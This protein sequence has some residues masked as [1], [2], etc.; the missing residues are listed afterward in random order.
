MILS[1]PSQ[2]LP[3]FTSPVASTSDAVN[4]LGSIRIPG[5]PPQ[6]CAG[7]H[8]TERS[9][10]AKPSCPS[11]GAQGICAP[12]QPGGAQHLQP[13]ALSWECQQSQRS[14]WGCTCSPEGVNAVELGELFQP[15]ASTCPAPPVTQSSV[16]HPANPRR[17]GWAIPIPSVNSC[18]WSNKAPVW[19]LQNMYL[20]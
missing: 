5:L 4:N 7:S 2:P 14:C 10:G 1:A 9:Q 11:L 8:P 13:L 6:P 12:G 15:M 18:R 19:C 16:G 3:G 17:T 20:I